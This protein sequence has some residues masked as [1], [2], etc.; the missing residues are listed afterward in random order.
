[1]E[2]SNK[3]YESILLLKSSLDDQA[4]Q[5]AVEQCCQD[6]KVNGAE[7]E[8]IES[9]GRRK[10]A[11]GEKE[12]EYANYINIIFQ[13]SNPDVIEKFNAK[14]NINDQVLKYQTHRV[15]LNKKTYKVNKRLQALTEA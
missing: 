3:N 14:L 15:G 11:H 1:M 7:I 8:K 4:L 12:G 6:L 5:T 13:A 10:V 9:W 2:S